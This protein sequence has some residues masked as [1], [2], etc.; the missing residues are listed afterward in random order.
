MLPECVFPSFLHLF[1]S[2]RRSATL[3]MNSA[4]CPTTRSRTFSRFRGVF[5]SFSMPE[6]GLIT[7][8][9]PTRKALVLHLLFYLFARDFTFLKR[10]RCLADPAMGSIDGSAAW[11]RTLGGPMGAPY[12]RTTIAMSLAAVIAFRTSAGG[13]FS[14]PRYLRIRGFFHQ[15]GMKFQKKPL[16]QL[17]DLDDPF[18]ALFHAHINFPWSGFMSSPRRQTRHMPIFRT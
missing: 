16:A 2:F 17:H 5:A 3:P 1:Q 11:F 13:T 18:Q 15:N 6:H 7:L 4:Y 14:F 12:G 8:A 9:F 10:F